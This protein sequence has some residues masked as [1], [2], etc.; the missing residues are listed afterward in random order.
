MN[1]GNDESCAG[2]LCPFPLQAASFPPRHSLP[3]TS[4][5]TFPLK[6]VGKWKRISKSADEMLIHPI[7]ALLSPS[8]KAKNKQIT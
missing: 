8:H 5:S 4:P 3:P 1:K 6:L 7:S 2:L